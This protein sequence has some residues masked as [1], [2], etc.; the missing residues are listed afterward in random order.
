MRFCAMNGLSHRISHS[1]KLSE[2]ETRE[3]FETAKNYFA[4]NYG[5]DNIA[6]ASVHLDE[7]T[8]HMHGVVPFKMGN[9]LLRQCLTRRTQ[10]IQEDLP[11]YMNEHGF[12]LERA[13]ELNSEAKHKTVA[14]FK[15]EM[16]GK[17]IRNS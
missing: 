17:E 8:P 7:S 4:E 10:K 9:C 15:Q 1:L 2:G 12:E 3:F 6:Y 11:K 16:A 5:E 14:E 13:S